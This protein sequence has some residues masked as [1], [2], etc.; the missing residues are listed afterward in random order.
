M[1]NTTPAPADRL[2]RIGA[3]PVVIAADQAME[4][5]RDAKQAALAEAKNH[6]RDI[7]RLLQA[8]AVLERQAWKLESL[9]PEQDTMLELV[10]GDDADCWFCQWSELSEEM[11]TAALE[12]CCQA[13]AAFDK[14]KALEHELSQRFNA[15]RD[16]RKAAAEAFDATVAQ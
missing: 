12:R 13:A 15:W 3:D 8:A 11:E 6:L 16:A 5:V 2:E 1:T 14:H 7:P 4:K 9:T 10:T